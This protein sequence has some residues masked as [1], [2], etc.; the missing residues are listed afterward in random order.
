MLL[1]HGHPLSS[2]RFRVI[3]GQGRKGD[4][5]RVEQEVHVVKEWLYKLLNRLLAP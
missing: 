3:Y 1:L 2:N 5:L 4:G